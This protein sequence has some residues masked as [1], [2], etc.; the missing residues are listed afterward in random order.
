[1]KT[2]TKQK[3]AKPEKHR[4]TLYIDADVYENF[5]RKCNGV[6]VSNVIEAIMR[7]AEL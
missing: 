7:E 2:V 3:N 1:M 4:V 6:P 5:Q